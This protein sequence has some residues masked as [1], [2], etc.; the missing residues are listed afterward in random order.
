MLRNEVKSLDQRSW[1][2]KTFEDI[3]FIQHLE[4]KVWE[5]PNLKV[6]ILTLAFKLK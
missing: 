6:S 1:V 2:Y 5:L 4:F 3:N